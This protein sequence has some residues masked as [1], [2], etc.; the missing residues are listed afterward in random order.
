V[1]HKR[2]W[3]TIPM[4]WLEPPPYHFT[5]LNSIQKISLGNTENGGVAKPDAF[6]IYKVLRENIGC[7]ATRKIVGQKFRSKKHLLLKNQIKRKVLKNSGNKRE[8]KEK[9]KTHQQK[10]NKNKKKKSVGS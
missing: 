6:K 2:G 9:L 7:S 5:S 8:S 3:P 4:G 1:A 10:T